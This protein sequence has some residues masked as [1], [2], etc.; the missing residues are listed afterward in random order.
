MKRIAFIVPYFSREKKF[1]Q[2]IELW[3]ASCKNNPTI[4]WLVY[5]DCEFSYFEVPP[6][7]LYTKCTF[8]EVRDK[9]QALFE[10][11]ISLNSPYKLCDFKPTYGEAFADELENYDFWGFCDV[12]VV[13]GKI[14]KYITEEMLNTY[15]RILTHGHCSLFRNT[16]EVNG[17]YRTLDR[18]GCMDYKDVFQNDKIMAFDEW[19]GH[20]GG[21]LSQIL[22]KNDVKMY[23]APVYADIQVGRYGLHTVRENSEMYVKERKRK[24]KVYWYH[25][26]ILEEMSV[27]NKKICRTEFLYAHFQQRKL[28]FDPDIDMENYLIIPP[29][30]AVSFGKI[31]LND[32]NVGN[33]K[34]LTFPNDVMKWNVRGQ[35]KYLLV[36]MLMK[37]KR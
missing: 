27:Y 22:L 12:D 20:N 31:T 1:P 18:K 11:E 6:N 24:N 8:E 35:I 2:M 36:R 4:D 21:G 25:E 23:E 32:I 37:I 9:I 15:D 7:V 34:K 30:K 33:L 5:T 17:Y 16:K 3:L 28:E 26:G 13:W 14:R 10:F 29:N 19:A